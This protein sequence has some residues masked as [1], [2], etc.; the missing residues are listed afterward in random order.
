MK[1][2]VTIIALLFIFIGGTYS[3]LLSQDLYEDRRG[4][5]NLVRS[6]MIYTAV[7]DMFEP[8]FFGH[9]SEH[10]KKKFK[11]PNI[12]NPTLQK[13]I[14]GTLPLHGY[15]FSASYDAGKLGII[16]YA[17]LLVLIFIHLFKKIKEIGSLCE[18]SSAIV[19]IYFVYSCFM[20]AFSGFDRVLL[21]FSMGI[22]LT[23]L[24]APAVCVPLCRKIEQTRVESSNH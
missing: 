15:L 4:Q 20:H 16:F 6:A 9:G 2:V 18:F 11:I 13:S 17:Y 14:D 19:L 24:G 23:G 22:V 3:F 7:S 5:S 8:V 10:F 12:E 1:K 21:G